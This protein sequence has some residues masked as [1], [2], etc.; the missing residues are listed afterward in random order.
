MQG[1]S[2]RPP[3]ECSQRLPLRAAIALIPF[4]AVVALSPFLLRKRLDKLGSEDREA[5]GDLNAF[6]VDTVQGLGDV[7]ALQQTATRS[8][9]FMI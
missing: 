7:L 3:A 2:R 5:L 6:V 1:R 9:S 4:L 8:K